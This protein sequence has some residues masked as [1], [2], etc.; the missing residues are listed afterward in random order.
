MRA[1]RGGVCEQARL[2]LDLND[3]RNRFIDPAHLDPPRPNVGDRRSDELLPVVGHHDEINSGIDRLRA[4]PFGATRHLLDAVPVADDKSVESEPL[5]QHVADEV[6]VAVH[7]APML[8]SRGVGEARIAHHHRLNIGLECAVISGCMGSVEVRLGRSRFALVLAVPGSA[9]AQVML[10][11]GQHGRRRTE[12]TLEAAH[13]RFAIGPN[14]VGIGAVAFVR[15]SPARVLHDRERRREGPGD[16]GGAHLL[17][18]H[19]A[20]TL[21]QRRVMRS[22]EPDIVREK[23]CAVDIVVPV[24]RVGSPDHGNL[25]LHVGRHARPVEC[26]RKL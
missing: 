6:G 12:L 15:A 24:D 5:L 17:G 9:V 26:V 2:Q 13:H 25:H 8:A 11:R 23:R 16:T 22:A 18:S 4:V 7:L 21:H 19:V 10:G 3:A 1:C 20:D 14:Q